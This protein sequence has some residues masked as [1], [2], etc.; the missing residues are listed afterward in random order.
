MPI[1]TGCASQW[2]FLFNMKRKSI[3]KRLR[4]EVFARD[5]F[6]CRY[7]GAKSDSTLLV[8]DHLH[9]VAQGGTSEIENLITSCE[10]CNQGKADKTLDQATPTEAHRLALAQDRNEQIRDYKIAVEATKARKKFRQLVVNFWCDHT[11]RETVDAHTLDVMMHYSLEF[12]WELVMEWIAK[13]AHEKACCQDQSM[14]RYVS[15]IRR[16]YLDGLGGQDKD[17]RR[18]LGND[19]LPE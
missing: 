11:G 3:G 17:G 13:A 2:A 8:I 16:S 4:F 7:C 6:T 5:A 1:S 12:G 18:T 9:P 14:G 15:G 10:P 19:N